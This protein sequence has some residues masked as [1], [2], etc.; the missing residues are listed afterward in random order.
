[1]ESLTKLVNK[2][3]QGLTFLFNNDMSARS[4]IIKVFV[5][6]FAI[7]VFVFLLFPWIIWALVSILSGL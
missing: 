7:G 2:L 1:M 6:V 4:I 5:V 3:V